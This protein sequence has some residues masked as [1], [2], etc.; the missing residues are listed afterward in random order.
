VRL[1][2]RVRG[3][4]LLEPRTVFLDSNGG[5]RWRMGEGGDP[6]ELEHT[7]QKGTRVSKGCVGLRGWP[8]PQVHVIT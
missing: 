2:V 3:W 1:G 6:Q 4:G 8:S 5:N 7:K